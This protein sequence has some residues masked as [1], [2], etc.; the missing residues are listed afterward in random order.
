MRLLLGFILAIVIAN[1]TLASDR[2]DVMARIQQVVD[3]WEKGDI[4][5][6]TAGFTSSPTLMD[7]FEPDYWQG[8]NALQDYAKANAAYNE[9]NGI[10]DTSIKTLEAT[11][12]NIN[13]SYAYVVEPAIYKFKQQGKDVQEN[14]ISTLTLQKIEG[15]WRISGWSWARQ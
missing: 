5:A 11:Y 9:K 14:G 6:V 3:A 2:T 13:G 7:E 12:L 8:P 10:T 15:S 1:P 4:A